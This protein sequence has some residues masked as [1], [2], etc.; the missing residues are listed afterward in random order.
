[1]STAYLEDYKS[2][3]GNGTGSRWLEGLRQSGLDR[4]REAGF[5]TS[6]EEDWRFLNLA[7]LVSQS[8]RL[9][10]ADAARVHAADVAPYRFAIPGAHTLVFVN[11][12]YAPALSDIQRLPAGA[13]VVNLA[14][15]LSAHGGLLQE[16]LGKYARLEAN[17]FT[18]LNTAFLRDGLFVRVPA[19]VEIEG[20]IHALF[21]SDE[22]AAGA[23]THPR[24]LILVDRGATVA[25]IESHIG[26]GD[27]VYFVN[28][29]TEAVVAEGGRLEHLKIQRESERAFHVG[30]T[31][32]QFGRDSRGVSHSV[33][34][35][36]ALCRNNLDVVLDGPGVEAQMFGLYMGRGKQEVDNHTSLL[37]AQPNCSTREVYKGILDGQS[38]GVFNGKIY[39]TPIAQKTDAKQTNRALLL[40]DRAT[41]DTKPQLE[42]FADD[43]KCT[44]GA[45]VGNLDQLAG[46]YLRSR[47]ISQPLARKILT[48]AFAAEVLE[49]I[50]YEEV[51]TALE[52]VVMN[53]LEERGEG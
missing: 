38:H 31:H 6:S 51:R 46:F 30:T 20:P 10:G 24:N 33:S 49:E 4:F 13:S 27:G 47:G 25:V 19:G 11:G 41:I 29:V 40:S 22:R 23:A 39:V 15:A 35:G 50:P 32:M 53:R 43:V 26:L 7:P 18:A 5:P 44:H 28:A 21:V 17:G 52:A 8:F 3:T 42:I 12:R 1:V 14:G 48:Y 9:A 2:L 16:H 45:T 36:A 34:F 37:H